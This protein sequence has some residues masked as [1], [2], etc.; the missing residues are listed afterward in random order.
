MILF[1]TLILYLYEP[2]GLI[3]TYI[4]ALISHHGPR[5]WNELLD[6]LRIAECKVK[7]YFYFNI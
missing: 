4:E 2:S 3:Q 7:T 5:L 6:K 1:F